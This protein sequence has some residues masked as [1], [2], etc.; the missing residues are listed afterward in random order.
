M[1]ESVSLLSEDA[2]FL[3]FT[4]YLDVL[5]ASVSV[6]SSLTESGSCFPFAC[7]IKV[8]IV[9]DLHFCS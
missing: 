9:F 7:I 8:E 1:W 4:M 3:R 5:T 6:I 2:T